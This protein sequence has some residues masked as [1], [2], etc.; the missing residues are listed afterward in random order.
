MRF[1]RMK[2]MLFALI[3]MGVTPLIT[4]A[5]CDYQRQAELSRI[6][7]NVQFSYNYNMNEGL[8]FT[9]YVNNLTDDI[10]VVDSYGQRL[11]GTGEKQLIYSPSRVSGFQSG[12]QVR[13]EIYSND[14][15]CPNNLLIT[16]YVNFPI[17]NPYSNL[18]DCKQNPNFKYCQ[19]WMDTSSVTHEQFT[20][21][22]NSAKNQPTEEAEEIKQSIFEEILSVL[23]RPQIMIVGSILLILV[24][25]SLFIYILKRKNIK[26]GRL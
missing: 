4:H 7:S 8:T 11:S 22:L 17:F 10:Y 25:I 14:S 3:C 2:Y 6:A 9:L 21:E 19:I 18:D 13:F 5:E 12:D 16:K 20:S 15:N 26:G 23:A 24:L 1:K